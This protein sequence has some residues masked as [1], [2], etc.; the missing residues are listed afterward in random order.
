MKDLGFD[1]GIIT[2]IN[3]L[4]DFYSDLNKMYLRCIL[5]PILLL[6]VA[7]AD[8]VSLKALVGYQLEDL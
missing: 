4:I 3:W 7:I 5:F 2:E 1:S 8:L 6:E